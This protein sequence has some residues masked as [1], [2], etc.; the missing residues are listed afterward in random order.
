MNRRTPRIVAASALLGAVLAVAGAAHAEQGTIVLTT[1]EVLSGEAAA[2]FSFGAGGVAGTY[3]G[4]TT[5]DLVKGPFCLPLRAGR[6]YRILVGARVAAIGDAL[7]GGGRLATLTL[8]PVIAMSR[9]G[10]LTFA[11]APTATGEGAE[12]IY[13]LAPPPLR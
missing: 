10:S 13:L 1:G 6:T 8:Y 12:G 5:N 2:K 7:P 4:F 9:A 11:A 3:R